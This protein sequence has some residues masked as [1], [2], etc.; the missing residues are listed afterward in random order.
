MA[1]I[2]NHLPKIGIILVNYNGARDTL[3]CVR[4][5]QQSTYTNYKIY[6][7][8]NNSI[9]EDYAL[10]QQ[11]QEDI[12]LIKLNENLGFSGGNNFGMR[13]AIDDSCEYILLLN[14]DTVIE[15]NTLSHMVKII[16]NNNNI[17]ILGCR[18]HYYSNK[19]LIWFAGGNLVKYMG[20]AK[21][22]VKMQN[23]LKYVTFLTGCC[24]MIPK[25]VIESL[26]SLSEDYFLYFED[27]DFCS[28]V[29]NSGWKLAVDLDAVVYHKVSS[30]TKEYS[31]LYFYYNTRNRFLF[32]KNNIT[33]MTKLIAYIY[34]FISM[35]FKLLK[36]RKKV[37][38]DGFW[39]FIQQKKGKR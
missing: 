36:Y 35:I 26:G 4:S 34:S 28:K 2:N 11:L 13:F 31:D 15:N 10:L 30:S 20:T 19:D 33:G 24:M 38:L 37:I 9:N 7:I 29:T 8:D 14:N 1:K 21:H 3:Q 16:N 39:D 32:I 18:I 12:Q 27:T 6:I 17:G 22:V 5:I 23:G 25:K